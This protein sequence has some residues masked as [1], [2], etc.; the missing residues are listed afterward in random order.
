MKK[1]LT[2]CKIVTV[3]LLVFQ[4][5]FS[6]GIIGRLN[7]SIKSYFQKCYVRDSFALKYDKSTGC[8]DLWI[9]PKIPHNYGHH[10]RYVDAGATVA[11]NLENAGYLYVDYRPLIEEEHINPDPYLYPRL[12]RIPLSECLPMC[13]MYGETQYE[14]WVSIAQ[15][16][17]GKSWARLAS[18]LRY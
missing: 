10:P 3:L 12:L 14:Y 17:V 11:L 1:S 16:K 9:Y 5:G 8:Y 2:I 6:S 13:R 4:F 18:F 15:I 7:K